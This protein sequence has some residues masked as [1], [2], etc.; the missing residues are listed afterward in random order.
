[1]IPRPS[2]N[3]LSTASRRRAPARLRRLEPRTR[4][5]VRGV[6]KGALR[7]HSVWHAPLWG[8][9]VLVACGVLFARAPVLGMR[10]FVSRVINLCERRGRRGSGQAL[11]LRARGRRRVWNVNDAA[12][13][14]WGRYVCMYVCMYV[15]TYSAAPA[16]ARTR[17]H[18][19][20]APHQSSGVSQTLHIPRRVRRQAALHAD[21]CRF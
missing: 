18:R 10:F 16:H 8:G 21:H 2:S 11:D 13:T 12:V 19:P 6:S 3:V 4:L 5:A 17:A 7:T 9:L 14:R 15:F 1:M 20:A